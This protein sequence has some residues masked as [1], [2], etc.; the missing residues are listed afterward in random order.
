MVKGFVDKMTVENQNLKSKKKSTCDKLER[1]KG[2]ESKLK[3]E[4]QKLDEDL[5]KLPP[6]LQKW[7]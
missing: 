7:V 4:R 3:K 6:D 1:E 5:K 2:K